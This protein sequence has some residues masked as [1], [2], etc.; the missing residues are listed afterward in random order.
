M[1]LDLWLELSKEQLPGNRGE[2]GERGHGWRWPL[3]G[4][5]FLMHKLAAAGWRWPRVDRAGEWD[6]R[7]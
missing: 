7:R 5:Q 4:A 6:Y 2:M 3:P 1:V